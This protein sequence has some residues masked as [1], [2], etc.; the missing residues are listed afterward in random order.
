M[1]PHPPDDAPEG[2]LLLPKRASLWA[3]G[4]LILGLAG[5][6][7]W[8][9][10]YVTKI[11]ARFEALGEKDALLAKAGDERFAQISVRLDVLERDRSESSGRLIR[12][13]EQV[14]IGND[15]LREIREAMRATPRR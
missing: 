11:D 4:G 1:L 8:A 13:E 10:A 5:H 3:V 14:R 15:L 12:L 2:A 6:L 7:V 9:G